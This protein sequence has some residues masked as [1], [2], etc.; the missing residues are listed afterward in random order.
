[1]RY[2]TLNK[3]RAHE[4]T[5]IMAAGE[6]F[7]L[8]AV[9]TESGSGVVA[10]Y[11]ELDDQVGDFKQRVVDGDIDDTEVFEGQ[12]AERLHPWFRQIPLEVLDDRG[13]WRYL[14]LRHFWWYIA[15]R[16]ENPIAAGNANT[17]VDASRPADQIPL[18]L[19]LR[20]NAV[21]VN[22]AGDVAIA[23]QLPK[24]TDFWR[25]HITR[26]RLGSVPILARTFAEAKRDDSAKVLTTPTLR[27]VARR[28]N[29]TWANTNL[30]LYDQDDA[31]ELL[32]E[33]IRE[34]T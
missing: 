10:P 2:K 7:G 18:R 5:A 25:S 28:L 3:A 15:W 32:A 30:D 1:M 4:A 6:L 26:V 22:K 8:D 14:A 16:E 20:T 19:Y 13:F 17:Y 24:S 29:R 31:V 11:E 27:K 33:A 9:A 23:A 21:D 34:E 12:L